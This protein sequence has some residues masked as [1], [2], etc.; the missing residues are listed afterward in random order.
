MVLPYNQLFSL[1]KKKNCSLSMLVSRGLR[2]T[3]AKS[4]D[5]GKDDYNLHII[6][7]VVY[8]QHVGPQRGWL[9]LKAGFLSALLTRFSVPRM[10][11]WR[12]LSEQGLL[13]G[14][15]SSSKLLLQGLESWSSSQGHFRNNSLEDLRPSSDLFGY[16]FAHCTCVWQTHTNHKK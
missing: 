13:N 4:S 12:T 11:L 9:S 6:M 14:W 1:K 3:E 16:T 8:F 2:D 5:G 7:V 15:Y 10:L